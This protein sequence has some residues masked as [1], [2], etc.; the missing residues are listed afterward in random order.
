MLQRNSVE[1]IDLQLGLRQSDY[2]PFAVPGLY[3]HLN[4]LSAQTGQ[5]WDHKE[6]FTEFDKILLDLNCG[7]HLK[8]LM[9][10]NKN[11]CQ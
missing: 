2:F 4:F 10:H 8:L 1:L 5:Q 11:K 7:Q 3:K 9:T 6:Q